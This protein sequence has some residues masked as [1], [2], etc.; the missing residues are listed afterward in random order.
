LIKEKCHIFNP[1]IANFQPFILDEIKTLWSDYLQK[2]VP[3]I[4][5]ELIRY[6]NN[7]FTVRY[8]RKWFQLLEKQP[9]L[10]RKKRF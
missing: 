4:A 10:V 3:Y 6:V 5:D 7:D 1:E 9:V 2:S 8:K